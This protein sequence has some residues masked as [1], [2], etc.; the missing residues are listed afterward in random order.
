VF[1]KRA[2]FSVYLLPALVALLSLVAGW[3][4]TLETSH[5][6]ARLRVAVVVSDAKGAAIPALRS[7]DFAIEIAGKPASGGLQIVAP[8]SEAGK[9]A[10][11]G[12]VVIV[13]DTV[14]TRWRDEKDVRAGVVRYLSGFAT[15]NAPVTFFVLDHDGNLNPLH[16][17]QTGSAT[18]AAALELATAELQKRKPAGTVSPEIE[19]ETRR[20]VDFSQ[21]NGRF[22]VAHET[23]RGY[24]GYVLAGMEAIAHYASSIPGRKSLVWVSSMIP[25]E[26][27]EKQSR[28]ATLAKSQESANERMLLTEDELNKLQVLWKES[29]GIL[30]RSGVAVYPVAVRTDAA[31]QV[32]ANILHAM[33]SLGR[34]TGGREYHGTGDPFPQLGDLTQG[35]VDAYDVLVPPEA[36]KECR[37]DWCALKISVKVPE[38]HVLAPIGFF[39]DASLEHSDMHSANALASES[40]PG[41]GSDAIPFS[42]T[43]KTTEE[44]G[45]KKKCPFIIAFSPAAGLPSNGSS[46]LKLDITVSASSDGVAKQT[47]TFSAN[48]QLPPATIEQIKTK[49]FALSNAIELEPGDYQLNFVV[50]DKL[51]GRSGVLKLPL[52]VSRDSDRREPKD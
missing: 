15:R 25:F 43:W 23:E 27:E 14:H 18:L 34:I 16:E 2:H 5:S 6:G 28:I 36:L 44:A 48:S 49:G 51:S 12:L 32:D 21:G 50:R 41:S 40:S 20:L 35:N 19:A 38:A 52:K 13:L 26:V 3:S 8:P 31:I 29:I 46:E 4:Q 42:V 11:R 24:P 1:L 17:Y 47:I 7:D 37:S 9:Q 30:Q 10:G 45:P 22:A 33:S 39:R